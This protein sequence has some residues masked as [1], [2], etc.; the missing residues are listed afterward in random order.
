M[1]QQVYIR[2]NNDNT[3][4]IQAF[5]NVRVIELFNKV[6]GMQYNSKE[7]V[8]IIPSSAIDFVVEEFLGMNAN[9]TEVIHLPER[10]II[11]KIAYIKK[12]DSCEVWVKF[13]Q[14]VNNLSK[15]YPLLALILLFLDQVAVEPHRCDI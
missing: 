14:N 1:P 5:Y 3:Y 8:Y 2:K 15:S 7:Q 9:V 12:G 10:K 6:E 13:S 4:T 11:P